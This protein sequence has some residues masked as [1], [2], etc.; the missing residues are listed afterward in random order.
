MPVPSSGAAATE[1]YYVRQ[2]MCSGHAIVSL[3]QL[4]GTFR[5]LF[6]FDHAQFFN[7]ASALQLAMHVDH[8]LF[9][10]GH[11]CRPGKAH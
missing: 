1:E 10:M 6:F 3:W 5:A 2:T 4:C 7:S 9:T 8:I 11:A